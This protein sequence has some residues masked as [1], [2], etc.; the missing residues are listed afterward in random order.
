VQIRTWYFGLQGHCEVVLGVGDTKIW[1]H[2]SFIHQNRQ[3]LERNCIDELNEI[4]FTQGADCI[5]V[6]RANKLIPIV[7]IPGE[8]FCKG[9]LATII[10]ASYLSL[11]LIRIVITDIV[12][13][14]FCDDISKMASLHKKYAQFVVCFCFWFVLLLYHCVKLLYL[15]VLI[16]K[17]LI[18]VLSVWSQIII[19]KQLRKLWISYK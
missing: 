11:P 18:Q 5:A 15:S 14:K 12:L 10:I 19:L 4:F 7:N 17:Q 2:L 8:I 6:V 3:I 1:N 9:Y 13:N 16:R